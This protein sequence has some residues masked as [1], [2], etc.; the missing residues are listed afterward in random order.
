MIM[1]LVVLN[2]HSLFL[3]PN[4]ISP[5]K[6][7]CMA[8]APLIYLIY[9]RVINRAVIWG[10]AY[11]FFCCAS[12]SLSGEMRFS[13]VGYMGLFIFA[14]I[15]FYS[16]LHMGAMTLC[17]FKNVIK[18]L[19]YAFFIVLVL[20]QLCLIVGIQ[21]CPPIN[22]LSGS[23]MSLNK[24]PSL[25]LEPS[26]TAIILT[27]AYLCYLRCCELEEEIKFTIREAFNL[28]HRKV[29][30]GYLWVMTTMGSASGY[31]GIFL[32]SLYF[33]KSKLVVPAFGI[34]LFAVISLA[35]LLEN[36]NLTRFSKIANAT[37]TGDTGK[38][39][40]A[41]GSGA[42]RVVPLVNTFTK[43]DL[44]DS[45]TWFG[46][47]TFK[48]NDSYHQAWKNMAKANYM[49]LPIVR[50]YGIIGWVLSIILVYTCCIRRFLSLETIVWFTLG[51]ATLA[52]VYLN[53]GIVMMM[54]GV[55]YFTELKEKG[56]IFV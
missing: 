14:F 34:L 3:E 28:E 11:F 1:Y 6:V 56:N 51:L 7:G 2:V 5:I 13:S 23:Y 26:H 35:P 22:L 49:V 9:E 41:D 37:M 30:I 31:I 15:A 20:E 10:S 40:K 48:V 16:A 42:T 55:K 54:A 24:L 39:A 50:Q 19:I 47:G 25:S 52:N 4:L 36:E 33:V 8:L 18:R 44:R 46:H 38:I 21:N 12:S 45:K 43:L 27:V 29:S 17:E 32:I 53:W